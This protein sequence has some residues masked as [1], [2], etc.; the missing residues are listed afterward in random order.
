[1]SKG[2]LYLIPVPLSEGAE[3]ASY[4]VFHKQVIDHIE[5]YIVENEK[6]ARR[7]LKAAGFSKPQNT[8]VIHDFGKHVRNEV[9]YNELFRSIMAGRDMGLMSD[10]GC[11]GVADPGAEVVAEA[12]KRGVRVVPLVGPSSIL[13]ALMASGFTGQ[14]FAFHG[15]LPIDKVE[16]G[17]KIKDLENQSAREKQ[18][19]LFIETP[20]RNNTLF[21]ELLKHLKKGTKL[22]I[23]CNLTAPDEVVQTRSVAEWSNHKLDLHKKPTIFLIYVH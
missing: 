18:T 14:K 17:R 7:F 8:L 6:T 4:T 20:F 3:E 23:A 16:R 22:C 19:Q 9:N 11:P 10:A 12:H 5:E 21:E 15:Y 13:L 1:M 2:T